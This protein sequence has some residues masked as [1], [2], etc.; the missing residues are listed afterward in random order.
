MPGKKRMQDVYQ[1]V[2]IKILTFD[3]YHIFS[4]NLFDT[5]CFGKKERKKK[6]IKMM[7]KEKTYYY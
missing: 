3:Y 7:R 1:Q 2:T 5:F 6:A 4:N